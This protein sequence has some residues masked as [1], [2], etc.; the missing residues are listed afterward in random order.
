MTL[1]YI[2][3]AKSSQSRLRND[4]AHVKEA[5]KTLAVMVQGTQGAEAYLAACEKL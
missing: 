1:Q 3:F 2:W 5:L 4:M